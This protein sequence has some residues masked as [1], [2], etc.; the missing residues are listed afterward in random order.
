MADLDFSFLLDQ[1][2][3][4]D[5]T[6]DILDG[7]EGVLVGLSDFGD[8]DCHLS[9]PTSSAAVFS[10]TNLQDNI[11]SSLSHHPLLEPSPINTHEMRVVDEM[12][13]DDIQALPYQSAWAD[14]FQGYYTTAEA[15]AQAPHHAVAQHASVYISSTM[16]LPS[17]VYNHHHHHRSSLFPSKQKATDNVAPTPISI[18]KPRPAPLK[19]SLNQA[20]L[21]RSSSTGSSSTT[22]TTTAT[23]SSSSGAHCEHDDPC[24]SSD[25][26]NDRLQDL[27]NFVLKHGHCHVPIKLEENP[28]LSKWAKRQ[29]YQWKLK[30]EG[31]HSTLT[32]TRQRLL[33]DMGFLWNVRYSVWDQRFQ[34]LVAFRCSNGHC[35]VPLRCKRFP[36]LGT[37]VKCQRRQYRLLDMGRKSNMT[38]ARITQLNNLG[39]AWLGREWTSPPGDVDVEDDDKESHEPPMALYDP[40]GDGQQKCGRI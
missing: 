14:L 25:R 19:V 22:T 3:I 8:H 11:G 12:K 6:L 28:A 16:N 35:N 20:G 4:S 10:S 32:T 5:T 17:L 33:E 2:T 40:A 39:F 21:A 13:L 29:R 24:Y 26:W 38:P 23:A 27:K 7:V 37:W 18:L 34:E 15:A 36:K 30:Q 1:N 31:K 9:N